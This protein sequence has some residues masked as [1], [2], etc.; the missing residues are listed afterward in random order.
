MHWSAV[1]A[2][3]LD[4]HRLEIT[5]EDGK[6]G[7]VDFQKYIRKGGVFQR[8]A[9]VKFFKQFHI[10]ADFGVICWGDDVDIAPESLY[11]EAVGGQ[12]AALVAEP[13]G[14]YDKKR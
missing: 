2:K 11:Q 14:K 10:N 5:F 12:A 4:G 6:S 13:K 8:L 7:I 1:S 9:D 3:Y